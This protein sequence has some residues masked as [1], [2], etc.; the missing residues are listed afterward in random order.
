MFG[1]LLNPSK[2][3]VIKQNGGNYSLA[4][5]VIWSPESRVIKVTG[6]NL[7]ILTLF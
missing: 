6:L 7:S 3:V 5:K 2:L 1:V 4:K